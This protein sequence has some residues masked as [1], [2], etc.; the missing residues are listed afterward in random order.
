V[1]K[2]SVNGVFAMNLVDNPLA[3]AMG[4]PVSFGL[5]EG[6]TNI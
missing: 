6:A 2:G 1:D 5:P 3:G 4:E